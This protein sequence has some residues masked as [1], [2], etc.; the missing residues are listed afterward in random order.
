MNLK[1]YKLKNNVFCKEKCCLCNKYFDAD[2][3]ILYGCLFGYICI[4]CIERIK[5]NEEIIFNEGR[6]LIK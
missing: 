3:P 4:Y 1:I 5:R 6:K 2:S